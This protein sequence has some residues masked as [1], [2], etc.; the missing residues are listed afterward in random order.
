MANSFP[1]S[2]TPLNSFLLHP[3]QHLNEPSA[4]SAYSI[5]G[6]GQYPESVALWHNPP[7]QPPSQSGLSVTAPPASFAPV[8]K[9]QSLLQPIPDQKKH[10]R[11]RSGCFTCRARR[12]KCDETRPVC[13][14]C[15][16]GNRDCVYPT[17]GT[18]GSMASAGSRSGAKSKAPRPQSRGSDSSSHVEADDIHILEPIADED[19]EEEGSV[20]SSSRLSPSTGPNGTRTKL[21]LRNKRSAQSLARRKAKQQSL[22]IQAASET[23]GS[24]REPSSSPSTEA[25]LRL[26]SASVRSVSVGLNPYES[27]AVPNAA[28]LPED[29][30]FYLAFHQ[31]YMT[32]RHYFMRS[33]SHRFVHQ[34][35]IEL[36]LQYDPLLYAVVGFAAYHHCVQT[37]NGKL[38]T[39]LK[40]YNMA[41]KML[42]KSLA[43]SE[44]HSEATL[45]TVLVLTTFEEFIGDWVNLIDHHQAAHALMRELLS[46]ESIITNELHGQIFPWYARFDVVAGILAGNEMVLGR[47]WYIAKE[48]Y[49]AQQAA[50]YPEDADKQLNLAASINRRFGL[51]MA[52]LYAKLSRG[53][54]PID[55]F[56]LQND[57]LGQLIEKVREIL[58]KFHNSEYTVWQYPDRQP[59]TEDDIVDPYIPG[60]MYRGPLW[61]VNVAWIDYY[62]TKAMYKYQS[63]LSVR[64]SSPSELQ[65]LA[66]EQC[67]LIEAIERWPEKENGYMF[68][69]KNSIGMACLFAPKDSKHAMWGRKRLAL[70]ERNGYVMAPKFRQLLATVWQ[71]PEVNHWWLSNDEGY[72]DIIREVR[73]MTEERSNTPRDNFRESVRNM[74]SLFWNISLDD[75]SSS[76]NS[77]PLG[78]E[79]R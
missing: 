23:P 13:D 8:P 2:Q 54:I 34:S 5:L 60:G 26:D 16:K 40:Y 33:D 63:L 49:D 59:L 31:G 32:P 21:D 27:F 9:S 70:L 57:Q 24:Y 72:P 25:S 44:D 18:S 75:S 17:P 28:H 15:R 77:S 19:E 14:R 11:T 22:T 74:R 79:D 62:S 76:N 58:E 38:Y 1:P 48:D 73:S 46:P 50:I 37:G 69:Y 3:S 56:I 78:Q 43:S 4:L 12:I 35:L 66:L 64:Q 51:E 20:G 53:M 41:L 67:R 42:R 36:A 29:V 39:F 65:H 68:T 55:E 6:P 47:E 61:D 71:S 30:R 7:N 45:I 10:K 52:S